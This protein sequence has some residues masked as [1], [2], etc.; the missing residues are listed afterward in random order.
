MAILRE[1]GVAISFGKWP[2]RED[3]SCVNDNFLL[4][5]SQL[6]GFYTYTVIH[7]K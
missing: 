6:N 4:D 2:K 5:F 3:K 7:I 1:I